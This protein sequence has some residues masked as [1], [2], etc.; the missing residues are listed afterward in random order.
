MRSRWIS[1]LGLLLTVTLLLVGHR[2][3]VLA[4]DEAITD[5]VIEDHPCLSCHGFPDNEDGAPYVD[6]R[7]HL[8][9]PHAMLECVGCHEDY[10]DSHPDKM[11]QPTACGACHD[12]VYDKLEKSVHAGLLGDDAEDPDTTETCTKC[13]GVHDI[14]PA[15]DR[16]STLYPLRVPWTCGQCHVEKDAIP[17]GKTV[18]EMTAEEMLRTSHAD[19]THGKGLLR[20]GLISAPTCATCHG[21][22]SVM[23]PADPGAPVNRNHVSGMCGSCHVGIYEKYSQ[24][25]H[26]LTPRGTPEANYNHV[27]PATC[28]DCHEPHGIRTP[29]L[30]FKLQIVKTCA[31]CHGDRGNTYY[32]TYHGKVASIGYGGIASCEDCHTAHQI[33]PTSNPLSSVN[34]KNRV[35]T[36][37]KCHEGATP[38]FARYEVHANPADKEKFPILY[39]ARVLMRS[40][41]L[42]TWAIWG[43]HTLLWVFRAMK[44]RK[45]HRV[46]VQPVTGRWYRRWPWSY[47]AIHLTLVV[48]FLTLALT[49]LPLRYFQTEWARGVFDVLGGAEKVRWIHRAGAAVT[50]GYAGAFLLMIVVRKLKGEKG[51]FRGPTTLIPRLEDAKNLKQAL[52][53]FVKGGEPPRF[54]RWTYYEKFD[55]IAEVWGVLFIGI[56][57][58]IMWFP[59]FFTSFLPAWGINLANILHSYEALL[60]TSFIFTMHFFNANLRPGKFPVDTMFLHGRVSEEELRHERPAEY[61]RMRQEGRLDSEALPPPN[62]R[63]LH[64]ARVLGI[65]LMSIGLLLLAFMLSTL[66]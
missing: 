34:P 4:D 26:G 62:G 53:W 7:V 46:L 12:D 29:D 43:I 60:A 14:F 27:E 16:R 32:A 17:E 36:C 21:G 63:V 66:F 42:G 58:L 6:P 22:H 56:T 40:V 28:T 37:A 5:Q 39:W 54:D 51:L 47:R 11:A 10:E 41:I 15:K 8:A 23:D 55:F 50:F 59:I 52:R 35:H 44:E 20:A 24:S 25:I 31:G 38:A 64:R 45:K 61:E 33:L 1:G 49:G 13:H 57:G 3:K 48:S 18:A 9:T 65:T 30:H 2:E 19:D